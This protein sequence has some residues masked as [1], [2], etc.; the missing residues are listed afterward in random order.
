MDTILKVLVGSRAHGIYDEDSDYDYRGVFVHPLEEILKVFSN[1]KN[2]NWIEGETDNTSWELRYFLEMSTKCNPTV[3]EVFNAP[4]KQHTELG[5][6]LISLFPSVWNT[7]D[8]VKA[9]VGYGLNQR[10]K[11][12]DDKD[13]RKSKYASAYLRS[14]YQAYSLLAHDSYPVNMIGTE[15][16]TDLRRYRKGDYELGEVI[17][18]CHK[19][20]KKLERVSEKV[21]KNTDLDKIN[22]FLLKA[23]L[24]PPYNRV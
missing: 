13:N 8:L 17:D 19:W 5:E 2:S 22:N 6:E 12:L 3:L 21:D 23:R 18:T 11:F 4:I 14:L 15:V 24:T 9:H 10:K 1:P 20:A 16:E 7:N